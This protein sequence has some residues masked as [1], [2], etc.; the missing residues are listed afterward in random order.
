[1]TQPSHTMP[2]AYRHPGSLFV[3]VP[4]S[5]ISIRR[6]PSCLNSKMQITMSAVMLMALTTMLRTTLIGVAFVGRRNG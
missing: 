6:T 1:M 2:T 5:S 4:E 3:T